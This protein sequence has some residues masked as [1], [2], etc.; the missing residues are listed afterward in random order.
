MSLFNKNN[1]K[2][3]SSCSGLFGMKIPAVKWIYEDSPIFGGITCHG[4]CEGCFS[5]IEKNKDMFCGRKYLASE[6]F[7]SHG[8]AKNNLMN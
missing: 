5:Q 4:Y 6:K 8:E 3:C 2:N 1:R 7:L